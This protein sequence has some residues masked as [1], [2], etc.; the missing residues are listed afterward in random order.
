MRDSLHLETASIFLVADVIRVQ[1][2]LT[3]LDVVL[4]VKLTETS[5]WKGMGR[6]LQAG[7]GWNESPLRSWSDITDAFV[8]TPAEHQLAWLRLLRESRLLCSVAEQLL[9]FSRLPL[10]ALHYK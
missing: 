8:V 6:K 3:S 10:G 7:M 9:C 4:A 2:S 5:W 1:F